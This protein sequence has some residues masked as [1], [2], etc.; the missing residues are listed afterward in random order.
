[1]GRILACAN[2]KG[3]VGKTTTVVN[4]GAYLSLAGRRILIVDLDPQGNATSGLGVDRANL[5]GSTYDAL[6]GDTPLSDILVSTDVPGLSLAPST[7][8][9]AGSDVELA[10][11]AARERRLARAIE[12][13][14]AEYDE[15]LIDCPPSL[16]LLTINALTASDGVLVPVQCE[17][18]ALEGL[19]QLI[20]TIHLVRDHLNPA[21]SIEGAVLTMF[22][23]RTNLAAQVVDE[24]RRHLGPTVYRTV[25]PRSVR[26][27][28]APSYGRPIATYRPDSKGAAAYDALA[29]EYLERSGATIRDRAI[30]EPP[31]G[32]DGIDRLTTA[33][34]STGTNGAFSSSRAPSFAG[35][36]R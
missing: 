12:P 22:D 5:E 31:G 17:Y 10:G 18:Y 34:G 32:H 9:L 23:P 33:S 30:V 14:V 16:G 35:A 19:G 26:L 27:S 25:I 20:G 7:I 29:R 11:Q 36:P 6:L 3:G 8:A 24:V 1:V 13:V 15:I 2:Q 21:L 4:L 28:E